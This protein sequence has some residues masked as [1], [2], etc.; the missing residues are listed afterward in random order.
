[1]AVDVDVDVEVDIEAFGSFIV[2][3]VLADIK[4]V[5]VKNNPIKKRIV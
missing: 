2:L 3:N 4:R 5:F 1:M